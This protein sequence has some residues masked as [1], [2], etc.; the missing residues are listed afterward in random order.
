M[1]RLKKE[2]GLNTDLDQDDIQRKLDEDDRSL[3]GD[4]DSDEDDDDFER[5]EAGTGLMRNNSAK[6]LGGT[7]L[8]NQ[9]LTNADYISRDR[10]KSTRKGRYGIT[11]PKPF[12]F[13]IRD[14]VKPK[15]IR[16]RKVEEMVLE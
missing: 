5:A 16:E 2:D 11:V 10:A 4:L 3:G 9:R 13:D 1:K 6:G 7:N 15:T 8:R 12:A 14:S